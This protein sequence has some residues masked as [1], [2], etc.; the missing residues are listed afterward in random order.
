[1]RRASFFGSVTFLCEYNMHS[2][3]C[4]NHKGAENVHT[5][6]TPPCRRQQMKK[7]NVARA[8]PGPPRGNY[9]CNKLTLLTS[10]TQSHS[11]HFELTVNPPGVFFCVQLPLF[12]IILIRFN[13]IIAMGSFSL[14]YNILLCDYTILYL[15]Y[16]WRALGQ[17]PV[18]GYYKTLLG[19]F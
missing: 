6:H 9:P 12:T 11:V 10:D 5:L 19:A 2:E 15:V 14:L 7:E 3:T 16:C 1:M 8:I 13:H 17:F 4:I 18:W